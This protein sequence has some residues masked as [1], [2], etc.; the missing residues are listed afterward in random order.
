MLIAEDLLLLLVD[1]ETGKFV[2]KRP[3]DGVLA[4]AL[5]FE[6]AGAHRLELSGDEGRLF[7]Q[8]AADTGDTILDEALERLVDAEGA[9]PEDALGELAPGLR[10]RLLDGLAARGVLTEE[11]GAT[12]G[13]FTT[14]RWQV[15]DPGHVAALRGQVHEVLVEGEDPDERTAALIALLATIDVLHKVVEAP[16]RSLLAMRAAHVAEDAWH[17]DAV[18]A[19]IAKG[20]D[21]VFGASIVDGGLALP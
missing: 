15:G 20:T 2:T 14:T 16:D 9:R 13:V 7:V 5:L 17:A 10:R 8:D 1:Q 11:A 18:E 21:S 3:L 19:A 12:L 4:G 6:L